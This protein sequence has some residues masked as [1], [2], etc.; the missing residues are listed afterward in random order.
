MPLNVRNYGWW[1]CDKQVPQ[2]PH[3]NASGVVKD[4]QWHLCELC[5]DAPGQQ[6]TAGQPCGMRKPEDNDQPETAHDH[7]K[8]L[9]HRRFGDLVLQFIG[10]LGVVANLQE[11][12]LGSQGRVTFCNKVHP[13]RHSIS[14]M[15]TMVVN[16]HRLRRMNCGLVNSSDFTEIHVLG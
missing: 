7:C 15:K 9:P 3:L 12:M 2:S 10:V 8:L 6:G 13:N 1:H 4:S 11:G 5:A 14:I 16:R